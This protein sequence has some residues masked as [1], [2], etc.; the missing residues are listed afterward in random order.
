MSIPTNTNFDDLEES[1]EIHFNNSDPVNDVSHDHD[2]SSTDFLI[3]DSIARDVE[4]RHEIS[5][6]FEKFNDLD[7][8][9][10]HHKMIL[11]NLFVYVFAMPCNIVRKSTKGDLRALGSGLLC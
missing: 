10:S 3:Y 11:P 6:L 1:D 5:I 9:S 8:R 2:I 7:T 4:N